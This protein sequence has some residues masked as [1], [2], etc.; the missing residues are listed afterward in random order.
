MIILNEEDVNQLISI[1]DVIDRIES[2]YINEDFSSMVLP[3]RMF[4]HDEE[5]TILLA[6]SLYKNY[7]VTKLVGI[8]PGN[9]K[10]KEPTLKGM[11]YV[12]D[13]K[14]MEP[15]GFFDARSITALRTGAVSGL[16]MKYLSDENATRVGII[17]TGV[18]GWSHLQAACAVRPIEDVYVYNRSTERMEQFINR[19]RAH[20]KNVN[21]R[22]TSVE[23]LVQQSDIIV[24]T[25]TS[26]KPV[27]PDD[28]PFD[29]AGK[30]IAAS[31]AFK[32]S[33]QELP[34]FIIQ[35]A[36]HLVVD[37]HAAFTECGEMMKAK[38]FGMTEETVL[39]LRDVVR[40]KENLYRSQGLTVFKSVGQASFDIL[41]AELL[42]ETYQNQSQA[43]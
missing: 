22:A 30:H 20:F 33:M 37:T 43:K 32:P 17:G 15:L 27:I 7:Y 38:A 12:S 13:R 1:R 6:P 31:G 16:S 10:L 21:I 11:V 2:F 41:T 5:N 34:D 19:A 39:T 24:T 42:Y 9:V 28:I 36:D 18:Q 25:T 26:E 35:K 3:E 14:T 40:S 4:I 8:A 29:L 23:E